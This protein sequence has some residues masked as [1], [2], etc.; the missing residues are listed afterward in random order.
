MGGIDHQV[1]GV[2]AIGRQGGEDLVEYPE[3]APTDEA[4]I[5]RFVRAILLGRITPAQ[6]VPDYENDSADHPKVINPRNPMGQREIG[7]NPAHLSR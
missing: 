7:F 2:T 6:P 3:P 1:I 5:D 4:I